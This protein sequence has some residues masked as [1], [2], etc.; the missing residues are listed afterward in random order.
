MDT[1]M[2]TPLMGS[3][4]IHGPS[5]QKWWRSTQADSGRRLISSIAMTP[6][7]YGPESGGFGNAMKLSFQPYKEHP[8]RISYVTVA[9]F[10]VQTVSRI[11]ERNEVQLED[12]SDFNVYVSDVVMYSSQVLLDLHRSCVVPLLE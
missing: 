1:P 2:V 4:M 11:L 3:N 12:D 5:A 8:K 10:L 9:S 6:T 7:R